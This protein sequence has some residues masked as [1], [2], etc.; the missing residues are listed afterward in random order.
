MTVR[1]SVT[2][3]GNLRYVNWPVPVIP[4]GVDVYNIAHHETYNLVE[5]SLKV[6][7]VF[8]FD[9]VSNYRGVLNI[10]PISFSYFDPITAK[11]VNY[12]SPPYQW[13][14]DKGTPLPVALTSINANLQNRV[15][16]SLSIK[17]EMGI[18]WFYR[19]LFDPVTYF[20]VVFV[21]TLFFSAG[22]S[23]TRYQKV[24]EIN[25]ASNNFRAAG[26]KA[27][28]SIKNLKATSGNLD[29]DHFYKSLA[30][31]LEQYICHKNHLLYLL[32]NFINA[33]TVLLPGKLPGHIREQITTFWLD[34]NT[35]RFSPNKYD[36]QSRDQI[37]L[38]LQ[39]IIK[40]LESIY[41]D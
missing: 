27:Y 25:Q 39:Q 35:T 6:N 26:K 40:N 11:Y 38:G 14:A 5:N 30:A 21:A 37:C 9:M 17:N 41:N 36:K 10:N 4:P 31:I 8:S 2:G 23:F 13:K 33:G 22:L 1:L 7:H 18:I 20:L 3:T 28:K 29:Q 12:E 24:R 32:N 19:L 16:S 15:T 34:Q